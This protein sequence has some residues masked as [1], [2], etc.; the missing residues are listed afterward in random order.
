MTLKKDS[1]ISVNEGNSTETWFQYLILQKKQPMK[2]IQK[3]FGIF[4]IKIE[5]LF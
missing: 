5:T 4:L 3:K 1:R 2:E